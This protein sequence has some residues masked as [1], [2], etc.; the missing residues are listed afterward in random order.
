VILYLPK[1]KY[2]FSNTHTSI[3]KGIGVWK[4]D[5]GNNR[6]VGYVNMGRIR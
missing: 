5:E 6:W 2:R 3:P 1:V 4:I